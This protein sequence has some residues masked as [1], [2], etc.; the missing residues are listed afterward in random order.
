MTVVTVLPAEER[1]VVDL[2]IRTISESS[3]IHEH[4][5]HRPYIRYQ[6]QM[7]FIVFGPD[8]IIHELH[9]ITNTAKK[10]KKK[11]STRKKY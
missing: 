3:L 1:G 7:A 11:T 8:S 4:T 5:Q 2:Y 10:K 6:N 9:L